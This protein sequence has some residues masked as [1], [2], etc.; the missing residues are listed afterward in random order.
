VTALRTAAVNLAA[1]N[2]Y[3]SQALVTLIDAAGADAS[4]ARQNIEEWFNSSMDRVSG[5][6]KRRSQWVL[7]FFGL[8]LAAVGNIDSVNIV[9]V[10][11][12][13]PAKRA[14]LVAEA[15]E[16]AK[17]TQPVNPTMDAIEKLGLPVGWSSGPTAAGMAPDPRSV[18]SDWKGWILKVLGI[19]MSAFAI[20][21]G[22]PFWFDMLNRVTMVRSTVKPTE[23]SP[24]EES[25]D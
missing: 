17:N 24:P 23:K 16:Y 21:L 19:L 1:V 9:N 11:S 15:Q 12:K 8:V 22:A 5:W 6:Y 10:L 14:A 25:K 20:S 7:V 18:P 4:R 3:V 13:D 2:P